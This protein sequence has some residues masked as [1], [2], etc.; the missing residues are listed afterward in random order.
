MQRQTLHAARRLAIAGLLTLG[1]SSTD[2][3]LPPADGRLA[4]GTWGGENAGVIVEDSVVHVHVDCTF[5]NFRAPIV[6]D[7][8]NRFDVEGSYVLRAYPI[9]VGPDLP[10]RF[11]GTIISNRL[12]F[13]I[14]VNDTVE[15]R[16]VTLGPQTV[17]YNREPAMR[18]CPICRRD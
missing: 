18:A 3:V 16:T 9:Q 13:S 10:A 1:C 8:N 15:H 12:V 5:G 2:D 17:V 11:A 7:T 4:V 14:I 6:L